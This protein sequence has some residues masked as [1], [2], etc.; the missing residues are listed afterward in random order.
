MVAARGE[1]ASAAED[2]DPG[3]GPACAA[4]VVPCFAEDP[5]DSSNSA[6]AER[7]CLDGYFLWDHLV[8][9]RQRDWPAGR[10]PVAGPR[11]GGGWH[12]AG[13]KLGTM[14]T[15]SPG[16][17]RWKLAKEATTLDLL[18]GGRVIL[19]VGLGAPASRFSCSASLLDTRDRAELL[20]EGWTSGGDCAPGSPSARGQ[21][22]H[23]RPGP[24]P[25]R[26]RGCRSGPRS[27]PP[28]G[29]GRAA[30]GW[31][32]CRRGP[33]AR[34]A[35]G[36]G[37][38]HQ[39]GRRGYRPPSARSRPFAT[40]SQA[41]GG[42]SGCF[43]IA[44]WW[45]VAGAGWSADLPGYR[46]AGRPGGSSPGSSPAGWRPCAERLRDPAGGGAGYSPLVAEHS[47]LAEVRASVERGGARKYHESAAGGGQAFRP[48]ADRPAHRRRQLH[49]GRALRQR[50]R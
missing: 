8:A 39:P 50:P 21:A 48:R 31:P 4:A 13:I 29:R 3:A 14:I 24:V 7:A 34:P 2:R 5:A 25:P 30:A 19:G 45:L 46:A 47:D 42:R 43:D 15:R 12:V 36:T 40:G 33:V 23:G 28:R 32:Q 9:C 49:R 37:R 38:S 26:C 18:S 35:A 10:G 6:G 20:D 1:G 41:C 11:C 17:G 44:V 27:P 16:G 22:L